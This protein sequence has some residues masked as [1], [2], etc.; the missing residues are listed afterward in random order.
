MMIVGIRPGDAGSSEFPSASMPGCSHA[1]CV[2]GELPGGLHVL[3]DSVESKDMD[4]TTLWVRDAQPWEESSGTNT[5]RLHGVGAPLFQN[6]PRRN[7]V[8]EMLPCHAGHSFWS[9][10]RM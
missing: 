1:G 10:D 3:G 8:R 2:P 7:P 5:H 4:L 6:G 9:W